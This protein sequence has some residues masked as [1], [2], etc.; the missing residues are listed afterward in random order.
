MRQVLFWGVIIV[1]AV[2][3]FIF[4]C[5]L[6]ACWTLTAL[7]GIPPSYCSGELENPSATR[8]LDAPDAPIA[9]IPPMPDLA[10][11]ELQYPQ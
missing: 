11:P 3:V 2:G 1:V 10:S 5:D 6:T 9:G 7:P 8:E 4:V